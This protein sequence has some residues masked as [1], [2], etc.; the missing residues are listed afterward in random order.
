MNRL[1][2]QNPLTQPTMCKTKPWFLVIS[3]LLTQSFTSLAMAALNLSQAPASNAQTQPAPN[4]VLSVD[5]SG[6]MWSYV[7]P[8][9]S[10]PK[11]QVPKLYV[12]KDSIHAVFNEANIP[13]DRIR[14]TWQ[15]FDNC[16]GMLNN[17]S[18]NETGLNGDVYPARHN[19]FRPLDANH[20]AALF[21]WTNSL[22]APVSTPLRTQW[23][24]VANFVGSPIFWATDP[25]SATATNPG[26]VLEC[27]R[28]YHIAMT[29]GAWNDLGIQIYTPQGNDDGTKQTLPDGVVYDPTIDQTRAYVDNFGTSPANVPGPP[30]QS[31]LADIAFYLWATDWSPA[32][33]KVMPIINEKG[34]VRV[35]PVAGSTRLQ[36]YWNAKNDP[37][38]WQHLQTY[39]IGFG[40]DATSWVSDNPPWR[41]NTWT[42][43]YLRLLNNHFPPNRTVAW[44]NLL[45]ATFSNDITQ[46]LWHAA[47]NGRGEFFPTT[48]ASGLSDSFRNILAKVLD[49][50]SQAIISI[51]AK[52]AYLQTDSNVFLAGYDA[53]EWSG[54]LRALSLNKTGGV[55]GETW[56]AGNLLNNSSLDID[57]RVIYTYDG[58]QGSSFTRSGLSTSQAKLI[59]S[60]S[61]GSALDDRIDYLRGD[62]SKEIKNGGSF[63]NRGSRLGDIVNSNLWLVDKPS[64][65]YLDSTYTA[66]KQSQASRT[67]MLYIGAN[68]GF[69][70]GFDANTG[71]EKMAYLPSGLIQEVPKLFDPNY[72][73]RY[74]V[75]GSPF[76]GD[77]QIDG[78]WK[79]VLVSGLGG[80]GKGYFILDVTDPSKFTKSNGDKVVIVDRTDKD[81]QNS[82]HYGHIYSPPAT[83]P[84][85]TKNSTQIAK[86]NNGKWAVVIG[87]GY[88][89]DEGEAVLIVDFLDNSLPTLF[90]RTGV[91]GDN[92]LANPALIDVNGDGMVDMAYAGDL[93]GNLWKFNLHNTNMLAWGTGFNG[94]P[95]FTAKNADGTPQPITTAPTWLP[96][97]LGGV[98]VAFGTGRNFAVGDSSNTTMQ[99]IY[100]IYDNSKVTISNTPDAV[101][102]VIITNGTKVTK[103]DLVEQTLTGTASGNYSKRTNNAVNYSGTNAKFGWYFDLPESGERI[104]SNPNILYGNLFS[105]FSIVPSSNNDLGY[106]SCKPPTAGV[107]YI[108]VMN[109]YT[110]ASPSTPVF[111]GTTEN[112]GRLQTQG[113]D[114]A[115]VYQPGNKARLLTDGGSTG[116]DDTIGL[117][118]PD[119][120]GENI[121]WREAK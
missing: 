2:K 79:T 91:I 18:C 70:H 29:D 60:G 34:T 100:G 92:G 117:Q 43:G 63:R 74:F 71:Q 64:A 26:E 72:T 3:L 82:V 93:Q 45:N 39:T 111:G 44:Q 65:P 104:L 40:T 12:L 59:Y 5:D 102:P 19:L 68:D 4:V 83:D 14:L 28:A 95:L 119:S 101:G 81:K 88:N 110:G 87:N 85:Y 61:S 86:M 13:D 118:F 8:R 54:A 6:S 49:D 62:Q 7:N 107:G 112:Y 116:I 106:E 108:N 33:N 121:G 99:T 84:Y 25:A 78:D 27:R 21:T 66:F 114:G 15:S 56:N 113:S 90:I 16:N 20:R 52:T 77:A 105:L 17:P 94:E 55:G 46:D 11:D 51:A 120:G 41:G 1:F 57:K 80:G 35:A 24:Q 53:K 75:D 22:L 76:S 98:M 38:T 50:T 73:H 30:Y 36:E 89:S 9:S 69:L 23:L 42:A 115:V 58:T 37:A 109:M 97:P 32:D 31:T 48:S 67:P 103:T 47:L 96:H 10:D